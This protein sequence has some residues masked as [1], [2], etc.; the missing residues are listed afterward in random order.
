M[1]S[2]TGLWPIKLGPL[3]GN[4]SQ[5]VTIVDPVTGTAV[6]PV[7]NIDSADVNVDL[8]PVVDGLNQINRRV[9]RQ[10]TPSTFLRMTDASVTVAPIAVGRAAAEMN[11]PLLS[12]YQLG[13]LS[14]INDNPEDLYL[15]LWVVAQNEIAGTVGIDAAE[16][17]RLEIDIVRVSGFSETV[18]DMSH[19]TIGA[20]GVLLA[21]IC[22]GVKPTPYEFDPL[23]NGGF[24]ISVPIYPVVP[25]PVEIVITP[26]APPA[27]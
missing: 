23:T 8:A 11:A 20:G 9:R 12:P 14:F 21:V 5:L 19:I 10:G 25:E 13:T 18:K 17:N 1:A 22:G 24:S 4:Y 16:G 3:N 15:K 27:P 6:A 7:V 2:K 26:P